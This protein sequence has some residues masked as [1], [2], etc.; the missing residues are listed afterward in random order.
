MRSP[1]EGLD[2]WRCGANECLETRRCSDCCSKS[3][4]SSFKDLERTFCHRRAMAYDSPSMPTL[5]FFVHSGGPLHWLTR[6]NVLEPEELLRSRRDVEAVR[7]AAKP[8]PAQ[9]KKLW[10]TRCA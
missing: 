1:D 2:D 3:L 10:Q 9:L 8:V 4:G 7:K 6:P 5:A